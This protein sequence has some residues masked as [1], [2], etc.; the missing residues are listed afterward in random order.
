MA[1][2]SIGTHLSPSHHFKTPPLCSLSLLQTQSSLLSK[3]CLGSSLRGIRTSPRSFGTVLLARAEDKAKGSSSSSQQQKAQFDSDKQFQ[4]VL[5]F[6]CLIK[7]R[8]IY[9]SAHY[10][11]FVVY[12]VQVV[13]FFW[14]SMCELELGD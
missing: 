14:Q 6:S 4:V 7:I 13:C 10:L 3:P 9:N 5:W 11:C 2:L 1:S 12:I 8:L